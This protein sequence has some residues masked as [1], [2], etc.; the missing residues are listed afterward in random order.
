MASATKNQHRQLEQDSLIAATHEGASAE[1]LHSQ[2]KPSHLHPRHGEP[3]RKRDP[4]ESIAT[5]ASTRLQESAERPG[6]ATQAPALWPT[7]WRVPLLRG[8][9]WQQRADVSASNQ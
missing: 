2:E 1:H 6:E 3:R 9:L 4:S 5:V 8:G 7:P